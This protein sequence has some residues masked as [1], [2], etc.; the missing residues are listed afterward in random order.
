M[1]VVVDYEAG[2]LYNVGH[3]LRRLGAEYV[4]S[5]EPDVVR[6]ADAVILPGVGSARAAMASLERRRLVDV[7]RALRV[8]F[9]GICLGMQLLFEHSEEDDVVCLGLVPGVVR[10]FDS[11]RVKVPHMG[12]NQVHWEDTAILPDKILEGIPTESYFYFV[13]SYYA[14]VRKGV[15]AAVCCYDGTFSAAVRMDNFLG[16]QFH[17]ERSGELG[18]RLLGNFMRWVQ[19]ES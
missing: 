4:M 15:T 17:P 12:W 19:E 5:G 11:R 2:N 9:L 13:H 8:P 6:H 10:R 3:A 7:L 14:P 16:V 18:L 1:L